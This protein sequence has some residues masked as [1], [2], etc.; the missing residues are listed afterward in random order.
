MMILCPVILGINLLLVRMKKWWCLYQKNN[1]GVLIV[2]WDGES[3]GTRS[4][5][6]FVKQ[7]GLERYII[8]HYN[9]L[10]K[11]NVQQRLGRSGSFLLS[12]IKLRFKVIC[13][14]EN[15]YYL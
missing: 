2:F 3:P 15:T 14:T 8:Y 1:I 12:N 13:I 4:M 10:T 9:G 7:Y 11:L 5:I 6:G